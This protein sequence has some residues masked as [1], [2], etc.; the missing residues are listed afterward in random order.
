M[1]KKYSYKLK[2]HLLWLKSEALMQIF[3]YEIIFCSRFGEEN[4]KLDY[5]VLSFLSHTY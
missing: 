1:L 5:S 3:S 4:S 2:T